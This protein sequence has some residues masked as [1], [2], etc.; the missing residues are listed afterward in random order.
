VIVKSMFLHGCVPAIEASRL[1]R[2]NADWQ[3]LIWFCRL[4]D[5]LLGDQDGI[6]DPSLLDDR[7]V[8]GLRGTISELEWHTIR[9]RLHTCRAQ[10]LE[11][12]G[13]RLGRV[14]RSCP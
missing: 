2:N 1:A 10:P 8:L 5:T 4:T 9:K 14:A 7:M 12:E 6:Y 3:C 13:L 11:H